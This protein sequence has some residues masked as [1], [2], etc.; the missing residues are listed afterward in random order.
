MFVHCQPPTDLPNKHTKYIVKESPAIVRKR[1]IPQG[2]SSQPPPLHKILFLSMSRC[3]QPTKAT[4]TR[5]YKSCSLTLSSYLVQFGSS[6]HGLIKIRPLFISALHLH[7]I[8]TTNHKSLP[9]NQLNLPCVSFDIS[10]DRPTPP[11]KLREFEKRTLASNK[12]IM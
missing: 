3:I 5:G 12:L 11:T 4:H 1:R 8:L 6:P 2:F 9:L 7:P 10:I